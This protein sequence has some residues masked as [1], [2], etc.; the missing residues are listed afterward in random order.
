ML[1]GR[2][3]Q[4]ARANQRT[5]HVNGYDYVLS[6]Y[7]GA[8]PVRGRYVEGNEVNDNSL[9]QGF[10]VEQ[11]P[12][13]VTPPHFHE[14]NQFQVFVAGSGKFGKKDAAPLTVHY[15]GG[16]TPYGPIAAGPQGVSYFTL[17]A[18]WD[19][20]A[21]YMPKSRDLLKPVPRRH[22]LM[23]QMSLRDSGSRARLDRAMVETI[24][25][26]EADGLAAYLVTAPAAGVVECPSPETG[27]GQYH[28]VVGGSL[29]RDGRD[30]PVLSCFFVTRDEPAAM[31]RGGAEG[32]E[33]LVLQFPRT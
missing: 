16:H 18:A 13:S 30:M 1:L 17:R 4:E 6:E 29:V 21:K 15:A 32:L 9:P 5:V 31:A 3:T 8:A 19:P 23:P 27:G 20:G 22:R 28:V 25:A 2:A 14:V 11:P 12:G 33:M 10:L 26:P 7:V 24:H